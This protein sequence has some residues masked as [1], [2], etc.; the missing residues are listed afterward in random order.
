MI[1]HMTML[2]IKLIDANVLPFFVTKKTVF[3]WQDGCWETMK[4]TFDAHY[5]ETFLKVR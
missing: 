1:I 4:K 3:K 2:K 5:K